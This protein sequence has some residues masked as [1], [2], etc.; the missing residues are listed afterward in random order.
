MPRPRAIPRGAIY[1]RKLNAALDATQR[2]NDKFGANCAKNLD[3]QVETFVCLRGE[4]ACVPEQSVRV[5]SLPACR[6]VHHAEVV[7]C[8]FSATR[9]S[10][11]SH[12]GRNLKS[13]ISNTRAITPKLHPQSNFTAVENPLTLK[14]KLRPALNSR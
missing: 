12:E 5:M 2:G 4:I 11:K 8:V 3:A 14:S 9:N 13:P 10:L 1:G 6:H 7:D